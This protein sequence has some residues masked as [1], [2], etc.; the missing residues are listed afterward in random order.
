MD[1]EIVWPAWLIATPLTLLFLWLALRGGRRLRL[2]MDTP[3]SKARGVFI[4]QV[5][6]AGKAVVATPVRSYLG[7]C[8]CV[9][10]S[11]TV[12]EQWERWET[13]TT[14][15]SKGRSQTRRVRKTG[16][17]TVAAGGEAPDFYVED[18][19]G[20]VRVRPEGAEVEP[21]EVFA[22]TVGRSDALYYGKGPAG[23][24]S[25]S[26]GRRRF[27]EKALPLGCPV[28]VAGR[29]REREDAVAAEIAADAEE[30]LFLISC[31]GEERVQRSYRRQFWGFGVA[32]LVPW[33]VAWLI[34]LSELPEGTGPLWP[35]A[36]LVALPGAGWLFGW[37]WTTFNSLV[38][39]RNRTA[40]AWSLVEVQLKRRA[41]LIPPLVAVVGGLRDHERHVQAE[42]AALRTQTMATP[43]GQAGPDF[44]GT[45]EAVRAVGERYP[46]LKTDVAFVGLQRELSDTETRV[47]LARDYFNTIATH[48]NTRLELMPDR[49]VATLAGLRPRVLWAP[50]S[51]ERAAVGVGA[52]NSG[53]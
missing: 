13:E 4:G 43:V 8:V 44:A 19:T 32:L 24:V 26:T 25:D 34:Q 40:Q 39:L 41:D 12:D 10:Y 16:W 2:L 49:W 1:Y 48:L 6:L 15:D 11:Y 42:L 18:E 23:G 28:F 33:P 52:V 36:A 46:A 30:H 17:S 5:E 21:Q 38:Q 35:L 7:G 47:A 53:Q 9:W 37:L 20:A 14:T 31:R 3:T 27:V 29:A 22:Q 50:E 45:A 51:F